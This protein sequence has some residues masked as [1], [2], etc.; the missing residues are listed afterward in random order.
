M[1]HWWIPL[2]DLFPSRRK[3]HAMQHRGVRRPELSCETLEDRVTPS[4]GAGHHLAAAL[5]LHH[6]VSRHS[7]SSGTTTTPPSTGSPGG[8]TLPLPGRLYPGHTT[9]PVTLPGG[10]WGHGGQSS[11]T[12][13]QTALKNLRTEV[14]T[15]EAASGTTVGQLT[16]IRTAFRTLAVTDKLTPTSNSAFQSFENSLVTTNAATPGSLTGNTTLQSQF[17]ALFTSS[18]TSQQTSDLD[19][20]YS[21]LVAAV[22]SANISSADITAINTDWS[23]VLTA[24]N[25]TSTATFPYFTLVTGQGAGACVAPVAI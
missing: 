13:L 22:T 6:E 4:H 19:A 17:A 16:A 10:H 18:P 24:A 21:A 14:Q 8:I 9:P 12:A 23:A 7:H 20:A 25:S 2:A 5:N 11:N 15:I 1:N 3:F